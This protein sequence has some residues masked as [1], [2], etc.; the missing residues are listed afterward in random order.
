MAALHDET[1]AR[2]EQYTPQ[3]F[4]S[5]VLRRTLEEKISTAYTVVNVYAQ[6]IHRIPATATMQLAQPIVSGG[7]T[8]AAVRDVFNKMRTCATW[9]Q[10]RI[11]DESL[12][13]VPHRSSGL[14]I[15]SI[16]R[17]LRVASQCID[18]HARALRD[19]P[20]I[21]NATLVELNDKTLGS[22]AGDLLR[23]IGE[24]NQLL[25]FAEAYAERQQQR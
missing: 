11:H 6:I 25:D 12:V 8:F 19:D 2:W 22:M 5:E 23:H 24:I 14:F 10:D 16:V 1:R 13:I 21:S 18:Q 17:T 3:Q 9:M 7:E 4:V 15:L 20:Q